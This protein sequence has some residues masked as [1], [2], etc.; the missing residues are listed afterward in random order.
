MK[1]TGPRGGRWRCLSWIS[2]L[3]HLL[4]PQC[5][6]GSWVPRCLWSS[7]LWL[8]SRRKLVRPDGALSANGEGGPSPGT[9]TQSTS[10]YPFSP[11]PQIPSLSS[12]S[13]G[14]F[15]WVDTVQRAIH[16][17]EASGPCFRYAGTSRQRGN[18]SGVTTRK[19]G[20]G[21]S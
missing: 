6:A 12:I 9:G 21:L 16:K 13:P 10:N 14:Q 8:G 15:W 2:Q 18:E 20:Q 11:L 5:W 3:L 17:I 4:V 19:R 1:K 7:L